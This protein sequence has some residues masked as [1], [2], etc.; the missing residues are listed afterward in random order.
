MSEQVTMMVETLSEMQVL[1]AEQTLSLGLPIRG[2]H[3]TTFDTERGLML[4]EPINGR[5]YVVKLPNTLFRFG[6]QPE[7]SGIAKMRARIEAAQ[8]FR[9]LQGVQP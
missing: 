1:Q 5:P 2:C 8:F 7:N 4:V 6:Y 3:S 9:Q